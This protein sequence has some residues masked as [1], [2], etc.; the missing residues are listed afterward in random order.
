[1]FGFAVD[2]A[3]DHTNHLCPSWYG[4]GGVYEDALSVP[5]WLS[6]AFCNPPYGK[7]IDKWLEKFIEQTSLGVTTVALLPART[8]SRWWAEGIIGKAEII[9]LTGRVPFWKPGLDKPSQPDH[10]S[11]VCIY[12]PLGPSAQPRWLDWRR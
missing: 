1:M 10:P 5:E 7:G 6:P 9:F 8:E 3:A 12:S 4:P 2:A 11:A